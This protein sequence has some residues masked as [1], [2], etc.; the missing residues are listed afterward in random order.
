MHL[1]PF[2]PQAKIEGFQVNQND[3]YRDANSVEDADNFDENLPTKPDGTSDEEP[4][5]G[6]VEIKH[7]I[8]T[9][10][11]SDVYAPEVV[12]RMTSYK[13]DTHLD[14]HRQT[15][16]RT[17]HAP[18]EI[19]ENY[20][21][22]MPCTLILQDDQNHERE[23]SAVSHNNTSRPTDLEFRTNSTTRASRSTGTRY[24][25]RANPTP[26]WYWWYW[27]FLINQTSDACATPR[28]V[29]TQTQT[30]QQQISSENIRYS[31]EAKYFL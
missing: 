19:D 15:L 1:R 16:T 7:G 10:P 23:N 2:V 18:M 21:E 25:L 17:Q 6:V 30:S 14:R 27:N 4:E 8:E 28:P 5:E 24:K 11:L 9:P 3:F 22:R 13:H 12:A 26:K 31:E 29:S 20:D